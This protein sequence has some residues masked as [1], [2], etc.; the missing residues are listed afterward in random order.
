MNL[1]LQKEHSVSFLMLKL[2]IL[3]EALNY[4][5]KDLDFSQWC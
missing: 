1:K 4:F 3:V 2:H 5:F